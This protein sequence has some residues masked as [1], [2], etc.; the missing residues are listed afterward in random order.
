MLMCAKSVKLRFGLYD[1]NAENN[2][3]EDLHDWLHCFLKPSPKLTVSV[4]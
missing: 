1:E 2:K 4:D 3:C